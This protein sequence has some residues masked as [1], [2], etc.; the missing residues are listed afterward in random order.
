M[1]GENQVIIKYSP[2]YYINIFIV[3]LLAPKAYVSKIAHSILGLS[4]KLPFHMLSHIPTITDSFTSVL[5][6]YTENKSKH[7]Y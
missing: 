6:S 4:F 3:F 1:L 2:E 5:Q 7:L